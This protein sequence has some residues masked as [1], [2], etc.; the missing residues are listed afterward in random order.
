MS[1]LALVIGLLLKSVCLH[2][3]MVISRLETQIRTTKNIIPNE[4]YTLVVE[5]KDNPS[6]AIL[7]VCTPKEFARESEGSHATYEY[8]PALKLWILNHGNGMLT[9]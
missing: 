9:R 5:N 8:G 3:G 1:L 7:D 6:F 2:L 4:A